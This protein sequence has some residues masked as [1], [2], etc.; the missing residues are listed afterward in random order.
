VYK[1]LRQIREVAF[2]NDRFLIGRRAIIADDGCIGFA[3]FA[4][5]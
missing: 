3:K 1:N 4:Y 2:K 5:Y